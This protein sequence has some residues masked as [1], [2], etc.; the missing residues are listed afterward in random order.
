MAQNQ[1]NQWPKAFAIV[2][3][4]VALGATSYFTKQPD[5]MWGML[6]LLWMVSWFE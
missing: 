3:G 1:N 5:V 6:P 2:F 4:T